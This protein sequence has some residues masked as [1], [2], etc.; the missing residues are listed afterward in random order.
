MH[1]INFARDSDFSNSAN[2]I[3]F[4]LHPVYLIKQSKNIRFF[5]FKTIF[6][7]MFC[8]KLVQFNIRVWGTDIKIEIVRKVF[9]I[10][11]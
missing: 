11:Y 1:F 6:V 10:S 4:D 7:S 3:A 5:K 9:R 8:S 2:Y